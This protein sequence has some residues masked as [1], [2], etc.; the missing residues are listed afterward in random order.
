MQRQ[1]SKVLLFGINRLR[2]PRERIKNRLYFT[3]FP[4]KNNSRVCVVNNMHDLLNII[5]L[6]LSFNITTSKPNHQVQLLK[7]V[8]TNL[9][10][11]SDVT[12][13][14]IFGEIERRS[15]VVV[16]SVER[17]SSRENRFARSTVSAA[18]TTAYACQGSCH[19]GNGGTTAA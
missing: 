4:Y 1:C 7:H 9:V 11:S 15:R 14:I 12:G 13:G 19:L 16:A 10:F 8:L 18:K 2:L 6:I 5:K 17:H 3:G